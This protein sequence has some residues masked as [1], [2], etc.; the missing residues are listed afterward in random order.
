MILCKEI[1]NIINLNSKVSVVYM[2]FSLNIC[3]KVKLNSVFNMVEFL[4][5]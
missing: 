1:I 3:Q 5:L 2:K 4:I